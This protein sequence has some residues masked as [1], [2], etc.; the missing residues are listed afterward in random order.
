[1]TENHLLL[2]LPAVL[3]AAGLNVQ[4][5]KGWE[6]RGGA[7]VFGPLRGVLCH[8]TASNRK[9][10]NMPSIT[11]LRDGRPD[12]AGPLCQLGLARDGTYFVIAAGRASH[13]GA[14]VWNGVTSGNSHLL[15][16]EAENDGIGE[17]WPAVQMDAYRRGVAAICHRLN[18]P[19]AMVAGHK[20]YATP[21]GR[22]IDPTFDMDQFRRDVFAILQAS[23]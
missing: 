5:V 23:A 10:G 3:T 22:K 13:A 15:G 16:I 1:M 9:A 14:G 18:L 6:K 17:P 8:H 21:K 20:E 19:V 12:L 4:T 7:G 11:I 2:W